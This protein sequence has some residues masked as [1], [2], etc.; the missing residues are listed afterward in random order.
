MDEKRYNF[1]DDQLVTDLLGS[2]PRV[3]AP[4][5]FD[6]RVR[7]RIAQGRPSTAWLIPSAAAASM[8]AVVLAVGAF[9]YL[10]GSDAPVADVNTPNIAPVTTSESPNPQFAELRDSE[11]S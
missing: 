10:R 9:V 4:T 1:E 5:N 7:S 2:L 11:P 6:A 3:E 8:C